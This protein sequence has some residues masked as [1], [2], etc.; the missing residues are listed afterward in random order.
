MKALAC[1]LL[2]LLCSATAM[3]AEGVWRLRV[4][5]AAVV[6]GE[7]VQ[8]GDIADPVGDMPAGQWQHLA[9]QNLW[10]APNVPG[11]PLQINRQRLSEAL[12]QSLGRDL[13][14][15]CLLPNSLAIQKGGTVLREDDLRS[16]VVKT[17][18][19]LINALG[20]HGELNDFRLPAY[21]FLANTSQRLD[22][23][24]VR[25]QPGRISLKFVV[26]ELDGVVLRRFTGSVF[27]DLWQSVPCA[28]T[29]L[30]RGDVLNADN[31]VFLNKNLA[32]VRG[33]LWDG[34][35]GPWQLARS[36]SAEQAIATGDLSAQAMIR[37]G[38][39]VNLVYER[40]N[41][42][43]TTLVEAMQDGGPGDTIAVKNLES[44]KQVFAVV[45]DS[46]TV[47]TK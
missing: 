4:R 22:L 35:G 25:V 39:K 47:V 5:E 26:K 46:N 16:L 40:G 8:L 30:N 37:K 9:E 45:R 23:E 15:A 32:Y 41:V 20:G 18:T 19:P 43:I 27:L 21:A 1:T 7:V 33:D 14:D 34:R 10:P 42:Q 44:K 2:L 24:D 6:Q 28:A 13:A 11:K 29:A 3:A 12:T 17:L 31:V 38:S 36:L